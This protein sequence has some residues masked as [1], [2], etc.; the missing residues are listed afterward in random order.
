MEWPAGFDKNVCIEAWRLFKLIEICPSWD[1]VEEMLAFESVETLIKKAA[2]SEDVSAI[3]A[4]RENAKS[5]MAA[6]RWKS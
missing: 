5:Y 3:C 2:T 6:K 1:T 4:V